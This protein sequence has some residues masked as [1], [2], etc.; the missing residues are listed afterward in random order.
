MASI[1]F[2]LR[3]GVAALVSPGLAH[4]QLA[5]FRCSI[6]HQGQCADEGVGHANTGQGLVAGVAD[7]DGVSNDFACMVSGV[8]VH[9]GVFDDLQAGL[10]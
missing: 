1:D 9:C 7:V 8:A 5:V 10:E 4:A 6:F 3:D 2:G